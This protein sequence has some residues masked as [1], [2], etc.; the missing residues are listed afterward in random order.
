M[1][2][3]L[4][5]K[6]SFGYDVDSEGKFVINEEQADAIKRVFRLYCHENYSLREIA[7]M[8]WQ[9][10][11]LTQKHQEVVMSFLIN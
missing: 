1:G 4:G 6:V 10:G 5:G 9:E 7:R 2:K 8:F 3:F 11:I